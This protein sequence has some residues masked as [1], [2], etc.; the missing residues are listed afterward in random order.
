LT[1]FP[2]TADR[3]P[4]HYKR[5]YASLSQDLEEAARKQGPAAE[6]AYK[7]ANAF[8]RASADR[9]EQVQRVVDK[10]G[11]PEKV[12]NAVMAGTQD[13]GT[14]VRAVMQSLPK[15]GQRAVTGAVIKRMGLATPGQQ[16][17]AGDAFSAST[18]LTNW[19]KVSPEAKRALFDRHGPAFSANMD[20]IAR[21]ADRIR[22]GS[23]VFANP[24]GTANRAAAIGYYGGLAGTAGAAAVGAGVMPL[25]GLVIGG[26]S[27]N[28]A[29][30]VMT[31]PRFVAW[32]ARATEMPVSALPQQVIVL[33]GIAKQDPDVADALADLE[34]QQP[35]QQ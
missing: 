18:F 4:A 6:Q 24:P 28:T 27:A 8:T 17:A 22:T 7:R 2:L 33:K 31:N 1:D 15:E 16:V 9:L 10:N 14:T 34:G 3:P 23:K 29:S 12:F 11:G 32:L 25:A 30:R 19:N 21:V 35:V 13:G 26:L 5:L 20:K